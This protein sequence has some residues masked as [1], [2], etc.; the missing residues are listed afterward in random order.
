MKIDISVLSSSEIN[1]LTHLT[2]E[3][4]SA[5]MLIDPEIGPLLK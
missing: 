1:E 5:H 3:L 4:K 2:Q